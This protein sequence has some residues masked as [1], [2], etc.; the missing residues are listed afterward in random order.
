M[1]ALELLPI[2]NRCGM[3]AVTMHGRTRQQRYTKS[4]DWKY[5]QS[6]AT[7]AKEKCA[8]LPVIANGDVYT[9]EDYEEI[10]NPASDVTTVMIARGALVK[11]WIFQEIRERRHI[12][13]SAG[14]RLDMLRDFVRYG[15]EHFGTDT[16]GVE[17]TRRFLLEML[18]FLHRY[19]PVG[20]LERPRVS[21]QQKNP[22]FYARSDLEQLLG[23]PD[24]KDWVR[25]SE[26][27]IGPVPDGFRFTPKHKSST[28]S[29]ESNG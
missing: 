14:E 29:E 16:K 10:V 18:S 1:T 21:I 19:V 13:I 3:S 25:I 5:I 22:P 2:V 4:A 27:L 28:Q 9:F 23:S 15:H 12:D 20:L 11:P 24:A 7:F 17:S 8:G 26:M 6:A